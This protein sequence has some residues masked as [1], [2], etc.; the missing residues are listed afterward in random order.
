MK[1]AIDTSSKDSQ[2]I[3][4]NE[5]NEV[6]DR[7]NWS[8]KSSQSELTLKNIDKILKNSHSSI[9]KIKAIFVNKGP[10]TEPGEEASFTGLKIGVTVANSLAFSLKIPVYGVSLSSRSF[11]DEIK[12]LKIDRT[13]NKEKYVQ[14][15]YPKEPN[16]QLKNEK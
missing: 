3:L 4:L 6:V 11:L 5:S 7:I 2:I 14:P 13:K 9:S 15:V 12:N 16:I 10:L 8:K 1:L